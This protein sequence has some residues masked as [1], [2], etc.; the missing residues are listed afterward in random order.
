LTA[1]DWINAEENTIL[2]AAIDGTVR[3]S[4]MVINE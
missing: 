3:V 1:V 2:T 4:R